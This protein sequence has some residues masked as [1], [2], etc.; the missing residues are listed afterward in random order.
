MTVLRLPFIAAVIVFV[1]AIGS[2]QIALLL[3]NRESDKQ[4]ERLTQVYLDGLEASARSSIRAS[5]WDEVKTRFEAA[6][7]SQEGV[8]EV[9]LRLVRADGTM[10][11]EVDRGLRPSLSDPFVDKPAVFHMDTQTGLAWGR[12]VLEGDSPVAL[13]VALDIA[14]MLAARQRLFWL[15]VMIDLIVAGLCGLAAYGVLRKIGRPVDGLLALVRDSTGIPQP[16]PTA[17]ASQANAELQPVFK[18]FNGM[19]EGLKDRERLRS[20]ISERNQAA[21]LGRLA[22]TI[23]H[24]VRNPLGGLATAVTTLR[25]FGG[26]AEVRRESLEFLARGIDSL[27]A[28]VTRTLNIYRP[29]DER[30]LTRADFEDIELLV[31]PAAAKREIVVAFG[32][33]LPH[34]FNVAA[35]GVRQVLLNL[36]LNAIAASPPLGCVRLDASISDGKLVCMISDEGRGMEHAHIR[37]LM[38]LEVADVPSRRIGMD[39]VVALLGDLQAKASVQETIGG[40]TT[41]RVEIPLETAS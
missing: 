34:A 17:L 24:E 35:S 32:L 25:K 31:A 38:G 12:R 2:T 18:A 14:E 7:E 36:M 21:A 6:F 1:V 33:D 5:D 19:V 28:L 9:A 37:K 22:A 15:I 29:E 40:G 8:I 30:R 23:A 27:D 20:E 13:V 16:V 3:E 26:D 11:V 10:L 39:A 41:V 4:T